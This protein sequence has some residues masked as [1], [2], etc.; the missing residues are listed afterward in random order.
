MKKKL[1]ENKWRFEETSQR[2]EQK[3][4][5]IELEEK[6]RKPVNQGSW[7]PT[8]EISGQKA[9]GKQKKL[10]E[11]WHNRIPRKREY[12]FLDWKSPLGGKYSE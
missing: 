3:C 4:W 6:E 8:N 10:S 12:H 11:K 2:V 1:K 7:Q 9:K 5:K